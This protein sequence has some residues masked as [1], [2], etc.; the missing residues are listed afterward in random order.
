MPANNV[1]DVIDDLNALIDA[2]WTYFA[3]FD[4][5][6]GV[7]LED[8]QGDREFVADLTSKAKSPRVE[9]K[10]IPSTAKITVD[11]SDSAFVDLF[12]RDAE[13]LALITSGVMKIV[14]H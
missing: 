10:A 4:G 6:I 14:S 8:D 3:L 12:N 1:D 11:M 9:E 5:I 7:V 13:P 2:N